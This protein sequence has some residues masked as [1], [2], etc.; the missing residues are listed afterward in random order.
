MRLPE[1]DAEENPVGLEN[2]VDLPLQRK[3]NASAR[4]RRKE[5]GKEKVLERNHRMS[6]YLSDIPTRVTHD[7]IR[8]RPR[9]TVNHSVERALVE[10]DVYCVRFQL[11]HVTDIGPRPFNSSWSMTFSHEVHDGMGEVDAELV[12]ISLRGKVGGECLLRRKACQSKV[13]WME[14]RVVAPC[15][16]KGK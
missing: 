1:T 3:K 13:R 11:V 16:L 4:D 9:T 2:A 6:T 15:S 12:G 7:F 10:C 5:G 8:R 14:P